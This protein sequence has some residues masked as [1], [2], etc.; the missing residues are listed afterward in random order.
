MVFIN[1]AL[2]TICFNGACYPALVG[3]DTPKG[4]FQLTQM[5]INEKR[6][7]GYGTDVLK[8]KENDTEWWAIHRVWLLKP[9]QRRMERLNSGNVEDR[10]HVTAGCVNVMPE[11]YEKLKSCCSSDKLTIE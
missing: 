3:N 6:Q 8:F 11:V 4:T 7:P 10:T 9:E 5:P 1:V 2:A